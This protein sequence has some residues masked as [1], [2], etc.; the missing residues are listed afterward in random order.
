MKPIIGITADM[1][2]NTYKLK[3]DYISSVDKSGGMPLILAPIVD[4]IGW[5]ADVIDGLLLSGGD[6]ILPE[7]Y[8]ED[9]LV[10]PEKLKFVKKQRS[11]F[12]IALLREIVKRQKPILAI[13]YGMQLV[14]IAFGGSLYQD[15]EMQMKGAISHKAGQ[16]KIKID[17]TFFS[18]LN[19]SQFA[20]SNPQFINS[21]HHQ[22]VKRLADGFETFAISEDGIIEG[23]YKTAYPFFICV[24]WHPERMFYDKLSL[25]IFEAFIKQ[26]KG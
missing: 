16:H 24:Q 9:I 20:I 11:D 2:E 15:I 8:G 21:F 1:D 13:C 3:H 10:P 25:G 18:I 26:A 6:D 22:A 17:E 12:E 19:I 23:F 4:N 14:N 5:I 7:Y